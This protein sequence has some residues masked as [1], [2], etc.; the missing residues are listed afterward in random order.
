MPDQLYIESLAYTGA[1]LGYLPDGKVVF[2]QGGLPGDRV[3]IELNVQKRRYATAQLV[4]LLEPGPRRVPATCDLAGICGGC[5]WQCLEYPEQLHWKRSFVVDALK[6][7]G[8]VADAEQ[9][10][11]AINA[12]EKIWNYRNKVEFSTVSKNGR[13]SLGKHPLNST[14]LVEVKR[15]HLL[16]KP[17]VDLPKQIAGTLN[18]AVSQEPVKPY[19]VGF[20]HSVR[21]GISELALWSTPSGMRRSFVAQLLTDAMKLDSLVRVLTRNQDSERKVVKTE[22][23]SGRGHWVEELSTRRLMISAPSFFQVN[24]PVAEAMVAKVLAIAEPADKQIWDLYCGA[25]SFTLPLAAA[26]AEVSAV[27]IA[28]SALRDLRRNLDAFALDEHVEVYSGDVGRA[29]SE[30][31]PAHLAV[32]DPPRAGLSTTVVNQLLASA[33]EQLVYVSCDPQTLARDIAY[34]AAGGYQL[35]AAYPFDLFPQSYHVETIAHLKR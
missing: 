25:G 5:P 8:K 6:R 34:L 15:C 30:L 10:V 4:E 16:P 19:R 32:L 21:T 24:T 31:E 9:L 23:L 18:Y 17:F 20:R 7:I 1:G 2:V 12:S 26:G 28:G 29:L 3:S 22:I 27:E 14:E 35:L 13:L 11:Q 33:P